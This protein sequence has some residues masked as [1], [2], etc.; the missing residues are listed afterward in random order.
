[1]KNF[2]RVCSLL[3]VII[4]CSGLL[5]GC[6]KE[7][8]HDGVFRY[9]LLADTPTL[10]PQMANAVPT[11]TIGAQL[12]E[13]LI[14]NHAGELKP[15]MAESWDISSD[16]LVYTFHIRD[17]VWSDGEPVTAYDFEYGMKRLMDPA[18]AS[19]YS[20][21][22]VVLK[23]GNAVSK[24]DVPVNDLGVKALDEK[25]LEITLEYPA[26]Y[27]LGMLHMM[28]FYAT[29][30]DYVEEHGQSFASS[31]DKNVYNGPFLLKEWNH[32]DRLI[33]E[34]NPNYWNADAV[35]LEKGAEIIIVPTAAT[36]LAMYEQGELDIVNIPP[37]Q[38]SKY[39][40][41]AEYYFNGAN[42][43]LKVNMDGRCELKNKN[44]RLAINY[45][46][47][48]QDYIDITTDGLYLPNTR[49][50]LPQVNGVNGE[51]GD[52]YPYSAY[53]IEGD[54]AKAKEYLEKAMDELGVTD[55]STIDLEFLTT[56]TDL[57]RKQ[58]EVIQDQLQTTLG[59]TISIRQ[60]TYK[61]RIQMEGDHEFELVFTGWAPDYSDPMTY[62]ELWTTDSGY[63][64]GSYSSAKYDSLIELA[65]TS[66]DPQE[67]MDAMFEAEKTILEDGGIVPIQLRREGMLRN[68]SL[69]NFK[70]YFVGLNYD[71]IYAE[72]VE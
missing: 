18:T 53:P 67:R 62:L 29:R 58:A 69:V 43:F 11:T 26:E 36:A 20:F 24:G 59:I 25:T 61:Q 2:K 39:S 50:V 40:E 49:Y 56:D 3:L 27:F 42:D 51:Y 6:S 14:R 44:L 70:T 1:M 64:H 19:G 52:E 66:T 12:F 16:G 48:R 7:V 46:L 45:A 28:Q 68:E 22:G 23:N 41:Q 31:A 10:D 65:R 21:L 4:L 55:P 60:V 37:E 35:K 71:W 57:S 8:K 33:L 38:I 17:A 63:N 9:S 15:G 54:A 30:Q 34:K 32:E 47:N 72:F 5:I 13:G